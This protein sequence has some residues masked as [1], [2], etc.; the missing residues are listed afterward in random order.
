MFS[1]TG[2]ARRRGHDAAAREACNL[3]LRFDKGKIAFRLGAGEVI[4]GWDVGCA[5][6]QI[7]QRRTLHI[8]AR[9]GSGADGAPPAIRRNADPDFHVTLMQ[10]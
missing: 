4:E 9:I 3:S 8:P 10:R 2:V 5:G 1:S 7:G 6:M